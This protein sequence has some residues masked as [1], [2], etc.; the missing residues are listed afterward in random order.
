MEDIF[1][2]L[3]KQGFAFRNLEEELTFPF[4][5]ASLKYKNEMSSLM[6]V[7]R[8]NTELHHEHS[9]KMDEQKV[10][11]QH[12]TQTP[13]HFTPSIIFIPLNP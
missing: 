10:A 8:C 5:T 6:Q 4:G 12:H 11:T 9:G 13:V 3:P 2:A 1:L 7:P